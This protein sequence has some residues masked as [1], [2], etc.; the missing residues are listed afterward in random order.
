MITI[1][2]S[3]NTAT[4]FFLISN[5]ELQLK[6]SI[7]IGHL[8][9]DNHLVFDNKSTANINQDSTI[10]SSLWMYVCFVGA[11]VRE[12]QRYVRRGGSSVRSLRCVT[13]RGIKPQNLR[14]VFFEQPH[15][16]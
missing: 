11:G 9:R 2:S 10:S 4:Y 15:M 1:W 7:L 14:Y 13:R 12:H 3:L 8:N 6:L 5:L 16:R